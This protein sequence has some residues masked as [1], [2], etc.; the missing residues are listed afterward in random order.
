VERLKQSD[1][2]S[3]LAFARECYTIPNPESLENFISRL[4]T[5]LARLIPATHVTYNEMCLE[6]TESLNCANTPELGSHRA[7]LLWELHM[8]E[9]PVLAHA[10]HSSDP[11]AMRISDFWGEQKLRDSGLH[12]DFYRHYDIED[13]LC[14]SITNPL[15][16][17]IGIGWHDDRRFT[18]RERLLADLARPYVSQAWQNAET[19]VRLQNQLKAMESGIEN[20]GAGIILCSIEGQVRFIN[21]QAR[22]Y[23]AEYFGVTRQIDRHLP[24]RL[25]LWAQQQEQKLGTVGEPSVRLPLVC[26][27]ESERLVV[28]LLSVDGA[29]VI[30]MEE[31]HR[32]SGAVESSG[33]TARE[34]EVL[35][36]I[37]R[38]K[39]NGEIAIILGMRT[40]T[41]K[42]HVEH[43]L[44]KLGVETRTGAAAVALASDQP[45]LIS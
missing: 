26:E 39:T 17:V 12:N 16:L 15:P 41:V 23:L 25:L 22:R 28:H 8:S 45:E 3:L 20:L 1:L 44:V 43:I 11:C 31:K 5:A 4:L 18:D 42:K 13:A 38:G 10:L 33:L 6:K 7:A 14:V 37:S 35:G 19:V 2:Q 27:R 34:G 30:M 32:L 9:H 21:A 40:S 36:W 29:N 24:D